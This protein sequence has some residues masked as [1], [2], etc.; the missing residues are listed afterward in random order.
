MVSVINVGTH[1]LA[2]AKLSI[3]IL[4]FSFRLIPKR[5]KTKAETISGKVLQAH[6]ARFISIIDRF[7]PANRAG[8]LIIATVDLSARHFGPEST[9][10]SKK[11]R[12]KSMKNDRFTLQPIGVRHVFSNRKYVTSVF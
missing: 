10:W 1:C 9:T 7:N 8:N 4:F 12:K 6:D 11:K 5:H 3:A 2:L